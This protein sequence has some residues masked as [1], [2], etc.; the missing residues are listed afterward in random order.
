MTAYLS[1]YGYHG[2]LQIKDGDRIYRVESGRR[3]GVRG[4]LLDIY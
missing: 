3:D 1:L 2:A 4:F